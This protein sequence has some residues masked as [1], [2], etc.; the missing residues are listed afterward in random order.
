MFKMGNLMR[1]FKL[2]GF[3]NSAM[4]HGEYYATIIG[5][6]ST[7]AF[8]NREALDNWLNRMGLKLR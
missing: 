5:T 8:P 2:V 4:T 1:G 3:V 7:L 6:D